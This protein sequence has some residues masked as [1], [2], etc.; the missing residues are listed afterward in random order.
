MREVFYG[1][2]VS[3]GYADIIRTGKDIPK[4]GNYWKLNDTKEGIK[5]LMTLVIEDV[6]RGQSVYMGVESTGGYENNWYNNF[7]GI[8]QNI[9][10]FRI[11]PIRTHHE[12]KK[13]MQRNINDKIS[14]GAIANLLM[15]NKDKFI[16]MPVKT[17]EQSSLTRL[18]TSHQMY[19]K[20]RT[21]VYT[22][23]EKMVYDTMPGLMKIWGDKC[24]NYLLNLLLK[25]PSKLKLIKNQPST[26]AKI[27]GISYNKAIEIIDQVKQDSALKEEDDI[28]SFQI[29]TL[30]KSVKQLN[31]TISEIEKKMQ[32]NELYK[33][34]NSLLSSI[35]GCGD[36]SAVILNI[37]IGDIQKFKSASQMCAY[38]GTHPEKKQSGDGQ[39]KARMSKKGSPR[40][41]GTLYMVA[42]NAVLYS[43]YFKAI[44]AS[45]RAKSNKHNHALGVIMNKLVRIIY[46]ILKSGIP[47]DEKIAKSKSENFQPENQNLENSSLLKKIEQL[48]MKINSLKKEFEDSRKAPTSSLKKSRLRKA[49]E[50]SQNAL[51]A[52][53]ARSSPMPETN[54]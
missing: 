10:I 2:D 15:D 40:F 3:K 1:I 39:T 16:S 53:N 48:S 52:L 26:L 22:S 35:P 36:N 30:V 9:H 38:F 17:K 19:I 13:D 47:F 33:T 49:I 32:A 5:E 46:G 6:K 7:Y 27:K 25:Y 31:Q 24:P 18:I 21:Q 51:E 54:I 4:N 50:E 44:Y 45:S 23:L 12:V 42:K 11:N 43:P 20:Q 28:K 29:Q 41:R 37:E 34:T 8:D 14:S